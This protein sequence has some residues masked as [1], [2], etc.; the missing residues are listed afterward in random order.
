MTYDPDSLLSDHLAGQIDAWV[1]Q[2]RT[3]W[4]L[5]VLA[6]RE[7][8]EAQWKL[9]KQLDVLTGHI[10]RAAKSLEA[11]E[12]DPA[13]VLEEH[14]ARFQEPLS[15]DLFFR[16]ALEARLARDLEDELEAMSAH[17]VCLLEYLV[18]V[19]HERARAY[20]ARVGACYLRGLETEA[21][22][23]AG[24]VLDAALQ[25]LFDDEDVRRSPVRCG[26]Y[27]SLGNRIEYAVYAG[28]LTQDMA[29]Q[30]FYVAR[31]R[32]H[33]VHTAPGTG[34]EADDVIRALTTVLN[35]LM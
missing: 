15:E 22:V 26:R 27:V 14:F 19:R 30:A 6:P 2:F 12:I 25:D 1:Q 18:S 34:A 7:L 20:L 32:N 33:A 23:M 3:H 10:V 8:D 21:I 11:S 17:A 31:E 28:V 16:Q 35:G 29:E 5:D 13:R 9:A 24:A 4:E